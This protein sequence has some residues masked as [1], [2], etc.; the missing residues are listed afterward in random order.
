[1]KEEY[2]YISYPFFNNLQEM[3]E[4]PPRCLFEIYHMYALGSFLFWQ[5]K[6]LGKTPL[7]IYYATD[8]TN[9]APWSSG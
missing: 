1:M 2:S 6:Q 4:K 9:G 7:N 3:K 5:P 8:Q